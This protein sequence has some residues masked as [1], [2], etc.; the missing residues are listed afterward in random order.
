MKPTYLEHE[1]A[2]GNS[3]V[4]LSYLRATSG[5]DYVKDAKRYVDSI[6]PLYQSKEATR[7]AIRYED[8]KTRGCVIEQMSLRPP[9]RAAASMRE[10]R[11]PKFTTSIFI[12]PTKPALLNHC[13]QG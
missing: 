3:I 4:C 9:D 11:K 2:M 6:P 13:Y 12:L 7:R 1:L 5:G 8:T 10:V